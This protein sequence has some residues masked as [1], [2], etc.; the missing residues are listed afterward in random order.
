V[1]HWRFEFEA[2]PLA[3]FVSTKGVIGANTF[4]EL[5]FKTGFGGDN[6]TPPTNGGVAVLVTMCVLVTI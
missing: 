4:F 2:M 1:S 6:V 3:A 5:D